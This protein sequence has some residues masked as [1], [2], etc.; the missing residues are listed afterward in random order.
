MAPIFI[1]SRLP[2]VSILRCPQANMGEGSSNN[3]S[4]LGKIRQRRGRGSLGAVMN[5]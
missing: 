4:G 2:I 5:T 1:S 3:E